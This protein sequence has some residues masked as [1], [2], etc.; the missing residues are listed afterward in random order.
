MAT[1][2]AE[3]LQYIFTF[4]SVEDIIRL[5]RVCGYLHQASQD[6]FV[7]SMVYKSCRLPRFPG[8]L[9]E[10]T[11][12]HLE[13]S[14]TQSAKWAS[15][16]QATVKS[17]STR[18]SHDLYRDSTHGSALF[19][20]HWVVV[21]TSEQ[22]SCYDVDSENASIIYNASQFR[23]AGFQVVEVPYSPGRRGAFLL[24]Q[25]YE[26]HDTLYSNKR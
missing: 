6:R 10:Q 12:L 8:P 19:I 2:P 23:I 16:A 7:W 24:V 5:R 4:L 14:L 15:S 17:H 3:I 18:Q 9:P 22:I 11:T 13:N 1:L 20:D 26:D 21:A 25:E